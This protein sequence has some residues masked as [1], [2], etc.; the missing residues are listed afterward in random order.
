MIFCHYWTDSSSDS[1][2]ISSKWRRRKVRRH[3]ICSS[4]SLFFRLFGQNIHQSL[5]HQFAPFID[6]GKNQFY[7]FQSRPKMDWRRLLHRT[8]KSFFRI[9]KENSTDADQERFFIIDDTMIEKS[10]ISMEGIS[11]VYDRKG[12]YTEAR[13]QGFKTCRQYKSL[14]ARIKAEYNGIPVQ[15]FYEA[16]K[17]ILF[18]HIDLLGNIYNSEIFF[19]SF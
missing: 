1:H 19:I 14:Y 5:H 15:L 9:V 10:G 3:W 4:T 6:G 11:R 18:T 7:R 2:S 17:S 16:F 12:A 13:A 8:V